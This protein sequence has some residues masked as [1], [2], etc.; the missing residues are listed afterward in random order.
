M[1]FYHVLNLKMTKNFLNII[2]IHENK[3]PA[4]FELGTC[5]SVD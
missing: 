5:R 2:T 4:V 1:D 3:F